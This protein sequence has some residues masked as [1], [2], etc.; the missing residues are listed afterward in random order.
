MPPVSS[1]AYTAPVLVP[2]SAWGAPTR[3]RVPRSATAV[4][5]S[6]YEEGSDFASSADNDHVPA[7][8]VKTKTRPCSRARGA[9]TARRSPERA[10][11][12][13]NRGPSQE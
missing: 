13:P 1:N 12:V 3:S 4:P 6:A 5:N 2:A 9:P 10:T 11:L 7:V 8:R